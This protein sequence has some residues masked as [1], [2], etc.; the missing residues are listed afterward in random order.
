MKNVCNHI[1]DGVA[2]GASFAE[3]DEATARDYAKRGVISWDDYIAAFVRS[4]EPVE[5]KVSKS[6]GR[7]AK[8]S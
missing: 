8:S 2:P 6:T 3:L 4:P 7:K 1:V 5:P